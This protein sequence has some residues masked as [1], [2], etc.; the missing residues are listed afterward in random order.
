MNSKKELLRCWCV[1][2]DGSVV[3]VPGWF[4]AE[5]CPSREIAREKVAAETVPELRARVGRVI[6]E[7]I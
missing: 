7:G 3:G 5:I 4:I 1:V 6:V 2:C